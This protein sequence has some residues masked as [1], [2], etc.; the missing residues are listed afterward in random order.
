V[1]EAAGGVVAMQGHLETG[2]P[3]RQLALADIEDIFRTTRIQVGDR[4]WT[5][6]DLHER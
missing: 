4:T 1:D 5:R 2:E 3:E 6:D